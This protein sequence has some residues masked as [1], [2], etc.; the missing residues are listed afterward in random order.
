MMEDYDQHNEK[1]V[2]PTPTNNHAPAHRPVA[3]RDDGQGTRLP[4]G[5]NTS[6]LASNRRRREIPLL[7]VAAGEYQTPI[8]SS[9]A[10]DDPIV[11]VTDPPGNSHERRW[12]PG[13]LLVPI[14]ERNLRVP[15]GNPRL[16]LDLTDL[17]RGKQAWPEQIRKNA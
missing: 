5:A 9:A 13:D 4:G 16:E 11:L 7:A 17:V 6:P 14:S 1:R 10:I 12:K 8:G 3:N 2:I 15:S